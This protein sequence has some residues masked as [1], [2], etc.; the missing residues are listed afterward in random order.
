MRDPQTW[1]RLGLSALSGLMAALAFPPLDLGPLVL[2][3]LIPLVWALRGARP[4]VAAACGWVYGAALL[5]IVCSWIVFFGVVAIV[6]FVAWMGVYTAGAAFAVAWLARAGVSGP[7]VLAATFT[8]AEYVRGRW[9][10]GGLAWAELGVA[11]HDFSA[12]RALASVGGVPLVTFLVVLTNA[13]LVDAARAWRNRRDASSGFRSRRVDLGRAGA[14]LAVV[15]GVTLVSTATWAAPHETG[16]ISYAMLQG[17]DENRYFTDAELALQPLTRKHLA[18]AEELEGDID[19]IVFPE[20]A[21][22]SDP[23]GDRTLRTALEALAAEHD[24][25]VL[26]N[27][28][29]EGPNDTVAN[30]NIAFAPDGD[31]LATYSKRHLV[32]F[33]EYVPFPWLR[34]VIPALSQIGRD[35][36]PGTEPATF[37]VQGHPVGSVICFES[38]FARS[39]AD[40][41]DEG[42]ELVVVTTNNRSYRRSANSAQHVA[43]TQMRA[44]EFA[45]PFLHSSISG[46]TATIDARGNVLQ[47]TD[48][49]E[50]TIVDGTIATTTGRTPFARFGD[51]VVLISALIV[52]GSVL[53]AVAKRRSRAGASVAMES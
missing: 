22:D 34:N 1:R 38:T 16:T 4:G 10:V 39:V 23:F 36:E 43:M 42:A 32:P 14:V 30:Q 25:V 46:I 35:Y 44:A 7:W 50:S 37:A 29:V 2:V 49:F 53:G 9:P 45:R 41:V 24:A 11:L 20:S 51:W 5:G 18:L 47:S 19:L 15:I 40:V 8:L 26:A 21:L 52:F 6:P 12:A 17:N 3:A 13:A 33:G 31:V 27:A 28:R 48:L